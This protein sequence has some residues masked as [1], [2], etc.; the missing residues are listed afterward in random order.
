MDLR[1]R[2]NRLFHRLLH[3]VRMTAPTPDATDPPAAYDKPAGG[4]D[5]LRGAGHALGAHGVFP[6][7]FTLRQLNQPQQVDCPGCAYPD[8]PEAKRVDFCEQG[9]W[10]VAHEAMHQRANPAFFTAHSLG[11]LRAMAHGELEAAGRLTAPMLYDAASDT[12]QEIAW[13]QAFAL[14]GTALRALDH[15]DQAVF[16]TSGRSSNEAAFSWQLFARAF[17]TNNLPDSSNYCHEASG[18]ALR[19]SIGVGKATVTREDFAQVEAIFIFGQ[20]PASN[21]P[22]MLGDLRAAKRRGCKIVVF[23][24]LLERGLQAFTDPQS[25]REML[26]GDSTAIAD[27]YYQLR[28]GGDLAA[29]TGIIR[30]MLE[31]EAAAQARGEASVLD[32][33]FIAE[34]TTGFAALEASILAQPWGR[35]EEESGL[36]RAELEQ[37]AQVYTG[38]GAVMA[39][40]CMGLTQHEYAIA[41][42]QMLTNLMLLCGNLGKPGA[43]LMP[44]RGHSNVQGD[45]TVGITHKP[46]QEWLD[47]LERV[48]GFKPPSARGLD[49]V[50]TIKGLLDGSVRAFVALGGNFAVAGP[51]SPRVLEALSQCELTLHIATTLNR[52]HLYPGKLGLLLPCLGRTER[53][54]QPS[55]TQF[56]S[57]EDTASMVHASRGR[58]KPASNQLRS[59]PAIVAELAHATLGDA[60]IDWR[61]MARNYDLTRDAIQRVTEGV[62]AGFDAYNQRVRE[63]RGFHLPNAA[64]QRQWHTE[65]GKA[66]FIPHAIPGDT[67]IRRAQAVHGD[68]VLCLATIR[69]HRQYNTTV[70]QDPSGEVDRY[71]GIHGS[72]KVLFI[73]PTDLERLGFSGGDLVTL[74][75]AALDGI[76]RRLEGFRLVPYPVKPGNVFGYFPELTPL[77]SI[78]L[79]ALGSNTP[80]FKEIPVLIERYGQ[81]APRA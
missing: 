21:H 59:E 67:I 28:I 25:A 56:V 26:T 38:A 63:G 68:K 15:P 27:H 41:T 55:G 66:R 54:D 64:S 65:V 77:A 11:Q 71:R 58:N 30:A 34:H 4:L 40:W 24:T 2:Y 45:R 76:E 20:N 31:M 50:G 43:G 1:L 22:R 46:K 44:V 17:G 39:T 80:A 29:L 37:A 23:N 10:A 35:I 33:A 79:I 53:D 81:A 13:E 62:V 19:E 12:Y 51:D 52:T 69:A 6:A 57:V 36:T 3:R 75:A 78:D 16:Y 72:R 7:V 32:Q 74:R 42:L 70:Y 14:A 8:S 49:A 5:A 9:A 48:F 47:S 60:C 73:S 18:D 61:A